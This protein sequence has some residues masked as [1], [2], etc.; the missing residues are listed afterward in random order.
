[1][2]IDDRS[3]SETLLRV[4]AELEEVA[5]RYRNAAAFARSREDEWLRQ[6]PMLRQLSAVEKDAAQ[7]RERVERTRAILRLA[8]L[9]Y[10]NKRIAA[11]LGLHASTVGRVI[12]RS[13]AASPSPGASR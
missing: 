13:V 2:N 8:S 4:A 3:G 9:G 6:P 10:S 11:R 12:R 1:M 5:R 7:L